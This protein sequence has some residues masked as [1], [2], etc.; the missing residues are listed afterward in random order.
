M[1]ETN[2]YTGKTI[3]RYEFKELIG[4]GTFGGVYK[5]YDQRL[6]RHVAIKVSF[7]SLIERGWKTKHIIREARINARA[8]HTNIVPIYDVIDYEQSVL[9]V[10]RLIDGEDLLRVIEG[11][12]IPMAVNEAFKIMNQVLWAMDYV[13]NRGVVHS[14]LKPGNIHLTDSGEA[15]VM[16]FGLAALLE[17]QE[18]KS[19]KL[20]GTPSCMPPEQIMGTFLDA[21][22]DIYSLGMI[23]YR[24]VTGHHP[25]RVPVH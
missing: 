19:G 23:L 15:I 1:T 2:S 14:D 12:D 21:R 4:T 22:S 8:E 18:T 16:D 25:L 24:M 20:F 7:P 9:I 17:E 13:H 5:A 3:D 10:M 6:L 11:R